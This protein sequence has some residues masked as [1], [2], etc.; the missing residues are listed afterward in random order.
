[1]FEGG[2]RSL[3]KDLVLGLSE[4]FS[5]QILSATKDDRMVD[6][7][8]VIGI[9]K[10]SL[11]Y[12]VAVTAMPNSSSTSLWYAPTCPLISSSSV[13]GRPSRPASIGA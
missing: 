2:R 9:A 3:S 10:F 8:P 7:A 4:P 6:G 1:M 5:P 11:N 13:T 12:A